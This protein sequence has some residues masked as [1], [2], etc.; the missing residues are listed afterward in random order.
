MTDIPNDIA[1]VT[2][3]PA[4]LGVRAR[5]VDGELVLD[6][7]RR[8]EILHHGV[9]RASVLAYVVDAIAG[10]NVD[11]DPDSW[12]F[13]TDLSIRTRPVAA[14]EFVSAHHTVLREG[15]RS[16]TC[17]VEMTDADGAPIAA[18]SIGFARVPRKDTDP[19]KFVVTPEMAPGLF[20]HLPFLT[21]P[22]R[23]AADVVAIDAAA[24]V[25]QMDVRP[26]VQN[27]AGTLQGGMVALLVE[28]A[29]EELVAAAA[30]VDV[31]VTDLDIRFLAAARVGPVRSEARMLGPTP[32][33]GVEVRV[34]DLSNDQL[35][36][37]AY[38][39]AV[40]VGG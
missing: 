36:T 15:K 3:L 11:G 28:S 19:P 18:G 6:L 23:D 30:G 29:A 27:P 39:R 1:D 16:I 22:L 32:H 5:L 9:I 26:D 4:L 13:T 20:E 14:P 33:D 40:P 17:E 35:T 21:S 12:S 7:H 38:A 2:F 25:V 31:V 34:R 8:P 37:L 10:L 24:G